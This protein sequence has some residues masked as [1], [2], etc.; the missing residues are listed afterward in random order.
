[1]ASADQVT[2][3]P[4]FDEPQVAAKTEAP[5][6]TVTGL[7]RSIKNVLETAFPEVTVEGEI[8]N[9]I[10]HRSG[11]RYFTL[12]D[13]GAQIGC[14]FWKTR[15]AQFEIA[16]GQ[17]VLCRGRISVYA[18]QGKYQLDVFQIR[19]L[20]IGALQL[21]YEKLYTKLGAEGLFDPTRKRQI[22]QFPKIIGVVTS[23][24]GAAWHDIITVVRRRYP[25]TRVILRPTTVQGIGAELQIAQAIGDLNRLSG[26][27]RPDV[28][29]VG[30]GGGSLEDLWCF[31]EEAVARAIFASQIPVI[32][33]VGHEVDVTIADFV[34]DLRAP[35]PT[36]AAELA[37]PDRSELISSIEGGSN[38]MASAMRRLFADRHY[39]LEHRIGVAAIGLTIR[40]QLAAY[41]QEVS[42]RVQLASSKL[43][44]HLE[45]RHLKLE[46]N[47]ASLA[48]LNPANILDRGYA[49]VRRPDGS[50]I[51]SAADFPTEAE[52]LL[53]D[54]T[55]RVKKA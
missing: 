55:V 44:H 43:Q 50:I 24:D 37:T 10:D 40:S 18:P 11:H 6:L 30:R 38:V 5:S 26:A 39:D 33:A 16:D 35:T 45:L 34:A 12:K 47:R 3:T 9:F 53:K 54:G 49:L 42:L 13:E 27:S 15:T 14:V 52:V 28:L 20:G 41:R 51:A 4:L 25:L 7:T 1:M 17:K 46:K 2:D 31:N 36:A 21:A 32:S 22:P 48:A 29:I 23:A 19:P 8:S